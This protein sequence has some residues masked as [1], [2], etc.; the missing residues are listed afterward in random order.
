MLRSLYGIT[1]PYLILADSKRTNVNAEDL[2]GMGRMIKTVKERERG[3]GG[4]KRE[5]ITFNP[6]YSQGSGGGLATRS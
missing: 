3:G 1:Y 2:D 6:L 4:G 5:E